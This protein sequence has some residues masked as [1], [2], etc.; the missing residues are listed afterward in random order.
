MGSKPHISCSTLFI[1]ENEVQRT[2]FIGYGNKILN[3]DYFQQKSEEEQE[4]T[5]GP[6]FSHGDRLIHSESVLCMQK[7][8][9]HVVYTSDREMKENLV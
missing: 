9:N 1:V 5:C 4:Y 3:T 8:V 2:K 6:H 7:L